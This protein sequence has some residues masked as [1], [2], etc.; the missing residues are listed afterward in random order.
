MFNAELRTPAFPRNQD[1]TSPATMKHAEKKRIQ[2]QFPEANDNV[3]TCSVVSI[4]RA[5]L[6]E[7]LVL[8]ILCALVR[9]HAS[10]ANRA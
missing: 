6:I 5:W 8:L 2:A 4:S 9:P 3:A 7:V 1:C 10:V